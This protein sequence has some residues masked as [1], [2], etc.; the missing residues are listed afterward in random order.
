MV[1]YSELDN[2]RWEKRKVEIYSDG[3]MGYADQER[4]VGGTFLGLEPIPALP[5][6]AKD[7][8]FEPYAITGESVWRTATAR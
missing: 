5:E 8:Q 2:D 7:P 3:R 6:I 4:A 1:L